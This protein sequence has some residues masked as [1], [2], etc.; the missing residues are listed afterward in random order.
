MKLF[1]VTED[2]FESNQTLLLQMKIA[3][4]EHPL[5]IGVYQETGKLAQKKPHWN[6]F[7]K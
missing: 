7:I 4:K 5:G 2:T 3:E 6:Y 1:I